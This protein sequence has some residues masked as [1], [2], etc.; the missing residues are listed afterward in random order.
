MG[1]DITEKVKAPKQNL[2]AQWEV[3]E[4][5]NLQAAT[6]KLY[7]DR[8]EE[9][10]FKTDPDPPTQLLRLS[11]IMWCQQYNR[12]RSHP[13]STDQNILMHRSTRYENML[14]WN[15]LFNSW[16]ENYPE[17]CIC[18]EQLSKILAVNS[19]LEKSM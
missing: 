17:C 8:Y 6:E 16:I 7:S 5:P 12:Q 18:P 14:Q 13:K 19:N 15:E 1:A 10:H 2:L 9:N 3:E 11:C 4:D